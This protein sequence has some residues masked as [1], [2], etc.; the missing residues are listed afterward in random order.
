MKNLDWNKIPSFDQLPVKQGAPPESSWGVFGDDDQLGCLNFLTPQGVIEA[1]RLVQN[2]KVFRLDAKIG[3][4]KP[5]LFGRATVAHKVV[6]LG[7]F[8]NDDV[9]DNFNTQEGSQWDGLGHVGHRWVERY[10]NGVQSSEIGP[11]GKLSIHQ[12][13]ARFVGRGVLI[14]ALGFRKAKGRDLRPLERDVITLADLKG[15]L[16]HQGTTLKPGTILLV[17]TGWME[18]YEQCTPEQKRPLTSFENVK[19]VGIEATREMAA[20]L[21]DQRVAAIGTDSP[22]VEPLP[23][24]FS[25]PGIL[26]Y[27]ALPLLGLP[28][29]ELFV[30]APLAEDC[31]R[32]RR[33]EF[34]VVS[35]PMVLEGGIAT[36]PNA[37]AI[38]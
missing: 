19:A 29:G 30:L 14:D 20:W 33:Y 25:D 27:R 11:G 1:A 31:A 38:K 37:V 35:A 16:E 24:D 10:Y 3:F 5:T 28:L 23:A 36:P 13:A 21:W 32:D 12:W 4:A 2:G 8:A 18:S 26:H 6:P 7:P 9:V 34:M 15:A 22:G 17:R